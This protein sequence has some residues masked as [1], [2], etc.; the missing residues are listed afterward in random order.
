MRFGMTNKINKASECEAK[1]DGGWVKFRDFVNFVASLLGTGLLGVRL[2]VF[3]V[4]VVGGNKR[5]WW[6][7]KKET[8]WQALS[9]Y[10]MRRRC[11]VALP[12]WLVPMV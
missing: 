11:W 1:R 9:T 3:P 4:D 10:G 8:K 6:V 2:N 12:I 7:G 5:G